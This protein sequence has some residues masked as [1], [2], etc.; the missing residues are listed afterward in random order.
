MVLLKGV[1]LLLLCL[2]FFTLFSLKAPKGMKAMGALANAAVASFL[3]EAFQSY[4]CGDIFHLYLSKQVGLAAG[5]MGGAAAATL[6]PLAL[7]VSPVYAVLTG[8]ACA[9]LGILPG[10]VAGYAVSFIIPKIEKK[11][12]DGLDLIVCILFI[13]PLARFIGNV[14]TP[15]VN[16]TLLN[17]GGIITVAANN[18]PM[19][20]GFI[21]G[22]VITVVATAPLS[23]MALTAM[24]G[25]T[26]LPMA[27]GALS[28]MS[29]SFM[30]FV[31]FDRMKFGDRS[32]TIAVSIEPL[33]QADVISANPIPIYITNFIGGGLAGIVVALFKLTNN[34]P[35]TATPI[36][37]LAVMYGFNDAKVTT[38][39]ALICATVGLLSGFVG[40][41]VFK[42]FKIRTVDEIRGPK[43]VIPEVNSEVA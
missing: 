32:T 22:G 18:N 3:V 16:S 29:S 37:G 23:S 28:V 40:S 4:V 31:F 33:T 2:S 5:G 21:L 8:C 15:I 6:V 42:N 26:G 17:I 38:I 9:G 36:A 1:M 43:K 27:V 12:P 34:A 20:M 14:A 19:I 13:A 35:G 30:N 7:G 11:I 24:L 41:L 39:A 25:L 10:F